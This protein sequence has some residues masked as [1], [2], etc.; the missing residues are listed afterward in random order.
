MVP[1]ALLRAVAWAIRASPSSA[2]WKRSS[3]ASRSRHSCVSATACA[4]K[5][6]MPQAAR[7]SVRSTR[8]FGA[9]T[10]S[11][12][13]PSLRS[14]SLQARDAVPGPHRCRALRRARVMLATRNSGFVATPLKPLTA[15]R[16]MRSN[17]SGTWSAASQRG[18]ESETPGRR[19]QPAETPQR[20]EGSQ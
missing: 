2:P 8:R 7:S 15:A 11:A 13:S 10:D 14:S 19:I 4:S 20:L 6:S 16:R 17:R 3:R 18:P 9:P 12:S 5:C 1:D